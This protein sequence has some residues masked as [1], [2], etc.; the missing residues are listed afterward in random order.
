MKNK[1]RAIISRV[2]LKGNSGKSS[3]FKW[4]FLQNPNRVGRISYG[5][6]SQLRS[7]LTK[8]SAK[9]IYI[10]DLPRSKERNDNEIDLLS[11]I[12]DLKTGFVINNMYGD[13]GA[14]IME[15]PHVIVSSN[16]IL[17]RDA[18]SQDRWVNCKIDNQKRLKELSKRELDSLKEN[19]SNKIIDGVKK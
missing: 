10:I 4:I 12:E 19:S 9:K 8:G 2:D 13:G 16:Y 5:S 14:L 17:D 6:S 18:L 1:Y 7:I 3:F 11:A 15:P